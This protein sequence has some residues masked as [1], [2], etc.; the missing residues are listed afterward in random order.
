[1]GID[2]PPVGTVAPSAPAIAHRRPPSRTA[3]K[4]HFA[5]G[6]ADIGAPPTACCAPR[7]PAGVPDKK[8][9]R[10]PNR[11][12]QSESCEWPHS[13]ERQTGVAS[14]FPATTMDRWRHRLLPR[15]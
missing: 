4:T 9:V 5:P 12:L 14:E 8:R 2:P 10:R 7:P 6:A 1:A 13:P 15:E 3:S 11:T